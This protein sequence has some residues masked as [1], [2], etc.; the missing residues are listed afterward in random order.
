VAPNDPGWSCPNE[1]AFR[2]VEDNVGYEYKDLL[3]KPG[4][5]VSRHYLSYGLAGA[6]L[7]PLGSINVPYSLPWQQPKTGACSDAA[8]FWE[9]RGKQEGY[10]L[11]RGE[12]HLYVA[13]EF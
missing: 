12:F 8:S 5:L 10:W 13:A 1:A 9:P 11:F 6:Y 4:D 7:S 3:E 2:S